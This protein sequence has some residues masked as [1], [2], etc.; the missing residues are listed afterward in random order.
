MVD[1]FVNYVYSVI[2]NVVIAISAWIGQLDLYSVVLV[3]S[4]KRAIRCRNMYELNFILWFVVY[5]IV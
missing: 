3:G 1:L 5:C 2:F 4:L